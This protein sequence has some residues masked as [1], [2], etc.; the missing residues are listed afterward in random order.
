[1]CPSG[2]SF[3]DWRVVHGVQAARLPPARCAA[4]ATSYSA[5]SPRIRVG[6]HSSPGSLEDTPRSTVQATNYIDGTLDN[7]GAT[8]DVGT[9]EGVQFVDVSGTSIPVSVQACGIVAGCKAQ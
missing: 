1:M 8:L 7:T 5:P 2:R 4:V 9:F 3:E 6:A